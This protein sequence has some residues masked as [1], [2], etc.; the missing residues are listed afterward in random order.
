[1]TAMDYIN[2]T[3]KITDQKIVE[4]IQTIKKLEKENKKLKARVTKLEDDVRYYKNL[5][6]YDGW[7]GGGGF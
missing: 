5:K 2:E 1:M 4:L 7:D 3:V 6:S